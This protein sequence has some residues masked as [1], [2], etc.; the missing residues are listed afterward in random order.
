MKFYRVHHYTFQDSSLG[1]AWFTSK[2]GAEKEVA[3]GRTSNVGDDY[4]PRIEVVEIKPTR[5]GILAA[6]RTY[7]AHPNNG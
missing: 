5:A 4:D 3:A 2:R 7:A 1:I 6:L